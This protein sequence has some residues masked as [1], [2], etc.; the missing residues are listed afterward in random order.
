MVFNE[1][2]VKP[3]SDTCV[4]TLNC[5]AGCLLIRDYTCRALKMLSPDLS[6]ISNRFT[7]AYTYS[8]F[9]TLDCIWWPR[10]CS[11]RTNHMP[12]R[13]T[14]RHLFSIER[15]FGRPYHKLGHWVFQHYQAGIRFTTMQKKKKKKTHITMV[16]WNCTNA[17]EEKYWLAKRKKITK[18]NMLKGD[19]LTKKE[20]NSPRKLSQVSP[21]MTQHVSSHAVPHEARNCDCSPTLQRELQQAAWLDDLNGLCWKE[22]H[23]KKFSF[24]FPLYSTTR[25]NCEGRNKYREWDK[26]RKKLSL[27]QRP[28][29]RKSRK[30]FGPETPTRLFRKAGLFTCCKGNKSQ[31]NCNVSC[32]ETPSF[33]RYKDNYCKSPE[34]R[35]KN[36]ETFWLSNAPQGSC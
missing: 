21:V 35:P 11:L 2:Q 33:W 12:A 20:P 23:L 9:C 10:F 14:Y 15:L 30:L 5:P 26:A 16:I 18:Q 4:D 24:P 8:N 19:C 28:V 29:S 1:I 6:L 32:L 22:N 27:V 17:A 7:P 36:F 34:M 13:Q 25:T 3:R 31:N